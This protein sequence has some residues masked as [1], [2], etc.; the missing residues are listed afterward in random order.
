MELRDA[1]IQQAP[2]LTLQRAA[3]NEIAKLDFQV[4]ML[5][6]LLD[7]LEESLEHDGYGWWL[8]DICIKE[9]QNSEAR[10]NTAEILAAI[11]LRKPL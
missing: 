11:I 1:L 9:T 5:V 3:A 8:P 6:D 10:P 2:S 4:N 7:I